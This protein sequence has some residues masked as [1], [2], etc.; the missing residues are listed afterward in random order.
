MYDLR[1]RA[2]ANIIPKLECIQQ[3]LEGACRADVC[4]LGVEHIE[5]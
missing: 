2:Q 3:H 5:P 1:N 4:V